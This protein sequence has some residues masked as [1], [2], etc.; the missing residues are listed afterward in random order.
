MSLTVYLTVMLPAESTY[1][2]PISTTVRVTI[3]EIQTYPILEL[4]L[5]PIVAATSVRHASFSVWPNVTLRKTH[6]KF[7]KSLFHEV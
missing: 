5:H 2:Q 1:H 3:P 6:A 7:W 4:S